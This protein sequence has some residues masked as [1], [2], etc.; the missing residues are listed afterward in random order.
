VKRTTSLALDF[1]D[2]IAILT[3]T[4]EEK[5]IVAKSKTQL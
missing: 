2:R 3:G 1:L 5:A 4:K